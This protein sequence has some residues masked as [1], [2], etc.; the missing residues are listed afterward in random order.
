MALKLTKGKATIAMVTLVAVAALGIDF[1]GDLQ[2]LP[3]G[4]VHWSEDW[5]IRYFSPFHEGPQEDIALVEIDEEAL[6]REG[7][8]PTVPVDRGWMAK[9]INAVAAAGPRAIGIDFYYASAIDPQKDEELI[10]AIRDAKVPIVI[11]AL[12]N[13]SL[14]TDKQRAYQKSFLEKAGRPS[15]H[16]YLKRYSEKLLLGDKATRMVDHGPSRDGRPSFTSQMARLPEVTRVYG[17]PHIPAGSQRISWLLEPDTGDTFLTVRA[18]KLLG[19]RDEAVVRDLKDRIVLIGPAFRLLD[20]HYVPLSVGNQV[21]FPGLFVQ[22]QALAQILEHRFLT[23]LTT[24]QKFFLLFGVGLLG[25]LISFRLEATWVD[26]AAGVG[27]TLLI[28]VAS[29][30]MFLVRVPLPSALVIL[31]WVVGLWLGQYLRGRVE[32]AKPVIREG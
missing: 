22:A 10:A 30:P 12:D 6:E 31:V 9:L 4:S 21:Q 20:R 11:A 32:T 2:Y 8:P 28:I 17:E 23:R 25:A 1:A 18:D 24:L 5:L 29:I 13:V 26:V 14:A 19:S 15:G 3:E 27:G 7:M 16:I